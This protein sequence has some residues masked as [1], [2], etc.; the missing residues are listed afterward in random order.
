M[1]SE[2]CRPFRLCLNVLNKMQSPNMASPCMC[3]F[4]FQW[5]FSYNI[6]C[7]TSSVQWLPR[8]SLFCSISHEISTVLGCDLSSWLC[9]QFLVDARMCFIFPCLCVTCSSLI[10]HFFYIRTHNFVWKKFRFMY[11]CPFA[12]KEW[13]KIST[14][15][16]VCLKINM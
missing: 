4:N 5:L 16:H 13:F 7:L 6:V 14:L 9:H 1:S 15:Q 8:V 3:F 12:L 11:L 10:I 2:K